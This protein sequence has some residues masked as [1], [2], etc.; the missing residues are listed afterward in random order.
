MLKLELFKIYDEKYDFYKTENC[1]DYIID[2]D[3]YEELILHI[4]MI[5][6]QFKCFVY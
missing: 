3:N 1:F 2:P 5:S 4:E 6:K